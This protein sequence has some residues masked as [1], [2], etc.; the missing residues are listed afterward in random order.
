[1]VGC[2]PLLD[3]PV[4]DDFEECLGPEQDEVDLP[5]GGVGGVGVGDAPPCPGSTSFGPTDP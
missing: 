2:D 3:H 5:I 1:M 4:F